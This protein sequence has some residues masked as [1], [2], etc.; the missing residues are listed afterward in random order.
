MNS[1]KNINFAPEWP[2]LLRA[3]LVFSRKLFDSCDITNGGGGINALGLEAE[4]GKGR[5]NIEGPETLVSPVLKR[6]PRFILS[7]IL[8]LKQIL[9]FVFSQVFLTKAPNFEKQFKFKPMR[10]TVECKTDPEIT[11]RPWH[12]LGSSGTRTPSPPGPPALRDVCDPGPRIR[13]PADPVP[14]SHPLTRTLTCRGQRGLTEPTRS[15]SPNPVPA[16]R[17]QGA[18]GRVPWTGQIY[19]LCSRH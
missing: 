9:V 11:A 12:S 2:L 14:F 19:A 3:A 15:T 7:P 4:P 8:S 10:R 6:F 5:Q 18:E 17:A 16:S 1:A 13:L